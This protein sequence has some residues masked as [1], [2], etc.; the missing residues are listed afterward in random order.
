MKSDI[1][2]ARSVKLEDVYSIAKKAGIMDD[3]V[4]PWGAYK[5]KVSLKILDRIQNNKDGKQNIAL[6][7]AKNE[8]AFWVAEGIA[9][10]IR[11]W[12]E[13]KE[14]DIEYIVTLR[15]SLVPVIG[16]PDAVVEI[17]DLV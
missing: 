6:L 13:T 4:I 1:E 5:A 7:L 9:P 8:D 3:E 2:I 17:T 16:R 11:L 10:Q 12:E 14:D 15:E